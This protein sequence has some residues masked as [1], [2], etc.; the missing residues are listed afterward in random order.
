ML[1]DNPSVDNAS[2]RTSTADII[3]VAKRLDISIIGAAP[4]NHLVQKSQSTNSDIQIFSVT[5]R[6][7]NIALTPKKTIDPA[8]KLPAEY[9]DFLDV[10]LKSDADILPKHWAGYD[11]S[12]ML[13]E[14]KTPTWG[15]L[16][17]MS[18]DELKVLKAYI[19]EMVDKGFIWASSSPAVSPVLLAKKPG[20][21]LRFCVDYR[22]FNA[23]TVKNRYPLLLIKETLERVCKAKIFSKIDIIVAF[24]KLRIKEGEE[25]KTAF[26][27]WYSLYKY[28]VMPFGLANGPSS[29]Q[30]Y[31]NDVLHGMLDVFCTAYI[32]DVL[33]YSN[34]KKEHREHV[35]RVLE[36]LQKA[37]LQAD[38][39]KCEFHV[40]KVNYL[41]LIITSNGIRIDPQ[42]VNAV[43]EWNTPICVQDVQAFIGFA[44]FYRQFI[45]GFLSI[46]AP[47]IA[48]VKKDAQKTFEWTTA[49]QEAFELLKHRFTTAPILAHF[50]YEKECIVETDA[51]DNVSA[52]VLSQYSDNGK[53][54]PVA[55]FSQKHSLQEINYEIY[56][57]KLL[58]IIKAFEEWRP[59]LEGAGLLIKI[60]TDHKNL[61][62]FMTTKQLSR[63]QAR[64]SKYLSRF[65][66]VIQF[67][68]GKLG[69]KPDSLTRRSGD[70]PKAGDERIKQMMQTVLKEHNL[71]PAITSDAAIKSN[72]DIVSTSTPHTLNLNSTLNVSIDTIEP[73]ALDTEEPRSLDQLLNQGYEEDLIPNRVLELLVR[74]ANYSKNLTIVDCSNVNGRLH[75]RELL[76]V[77][78]YHTLQLRLCK[79][80][81][82]TSIAGH[83]GADNTYKL[84]HRT[85]YWPD[86][87]KFVRQYV[88][89]CH[90]CKQSKGSRFKKQ[91]ML[92][93][94]PVPEQ[95]WQDISIDLV[96]GIPEIQ[97][98][99]AILN[100]VDRLSKERHYIRTTKKLN[101]EGLANFFLK[102]VW[103]HH[104]LPQ[105]IVSDRGSQ[106]V[107]DFWRF[108][109]KKL[110][111]TT[112]LS[113]AWHLETDGQTERINGVMEQYLRAFVNYLQDDWL[114]WLLLA[115]FVSNNTESETTKV[116]LFFAN[117]G[118]HPRMGFEPSTTRLLANTNELNAEVF[119]NRMEK[120]Q[121]ILRGHMLLA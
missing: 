112:Q 117:K 7:I 96:T 8:T 20:G 108:L 97:G 23:I 27:T 10:F 17:S 100:V 53:L 41:G 28:L 86:M 105:S 79:L 42:K 15:L 114:E 60:L 91:G 71:D 72:N 1:L 46:V 115:E 76:Y 6:D 32:D 9:H 98:C 22:A 33:I 95:R 74:D 93:P 120:I 26:R 21:G 110:G 99:D 111:V 104:G 37:G 12:I 31:I 24:N 63:R 68:Q 5:L 48:T 45:H 89:H 77:P 107:S 73:E 92:Q 121:N 43:Q 75:Y 90:V 47:M 13:V 59:M 50:N 94:L 88:R 80:H 118:F 103:K 52:S 56:D 51:S 65:N 57:K 4:F 29:F 49:C 81:H 18:A 106:F 66:F 102:H 109:C 84:L 83:L 3:S 78:N 34:S 55:F 19:E 11:H 25:W 30:T 35:R 14:G 40:T 44:N 116:T 70:L 113:T 82:D 69:A 67:W 64:W 62:Y 16:Y 2:A 38:I 36:A 101:A 119:V 58:A 61:Q 54:H 39:K 87:Q 85:Y